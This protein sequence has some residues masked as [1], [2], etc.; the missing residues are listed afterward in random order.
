MK[1]TEGLYSI[2]KET[3]QGY[4]IL[5]NKKH[6]I[7]QAHF[8]SEPITPGVCLISIALELLERYEDKRLKISSLDNIKF[9]NI[10]SPE[11]NSTIEF[12]INEI[13]NENNI[14]KAKIEIRSTDK[15]FAKLAFTTTEAL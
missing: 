7:Y 2:E 14:L 15:T 6:F 5:L 11:E 4:I 1:L 13:K 12:Y 9:I 8:P 3:T 10:V